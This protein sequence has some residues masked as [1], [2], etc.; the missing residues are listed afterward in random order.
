M[1]QWRLYRADGE[2]IEKWYSTLSK[3][4]FLMDTK[5]NAYQI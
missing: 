2:L 3:T 4:Y 5:F 1:G